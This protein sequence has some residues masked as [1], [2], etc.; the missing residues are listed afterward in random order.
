[1]EKINLLPTKHKGHTGEYWQKIGDS[2]GLSALG[3][4]KNGWGPIFPSMAQAI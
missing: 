4:F 2:T 1:M 3:P